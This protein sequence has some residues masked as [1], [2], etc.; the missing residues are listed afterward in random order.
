M[1]N[2][3]KITKLIVKEFAVDEDSGDLE[4]GEKYSYFYDE[5]TGKYYR[6]KNSFFVTGKDLEDLFIEVD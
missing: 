4:I 2:K 5:Q 3:N 1:S 6:P